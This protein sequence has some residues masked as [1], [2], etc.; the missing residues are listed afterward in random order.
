MAGD[1]ATGVEFATGLGAMGGDHSMSELFFK[2][3]IG[4][5]DL[6]GVVGVALVGRGK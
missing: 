3:G 2:D 4:L 1:V 5:V 6:V